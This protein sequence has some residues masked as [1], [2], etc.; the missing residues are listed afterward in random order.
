M[1]RGE[2]REVVFEERMDLEI[3]L[4]VCIQSIRETST[5]LKRDSQRYGNVLP[6]KERNRKADE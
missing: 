1:C 2:G 3:V 6:K 4:W 5:L